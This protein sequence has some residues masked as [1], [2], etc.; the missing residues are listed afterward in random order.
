MNHP[1][2][3]H[4]VEAINLHLISMC[5]FICLYITVE[6]FSGVGRR[7]V[8]K[9]GYDV[10]RLQQYKQQTEQKRICASTMF[11]LQAHRIERLVPGRL[12]EWYLRSL[13]PATVIHRTLTI[14]RNL[15]P[16]RVPV[17]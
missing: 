12:Y 1:T 7:S 16:L 17:D 5:P 4:L 10:T 9:R 15:H 14:T 8:A 6:Q 11:A 3:S 13:Q 2:V